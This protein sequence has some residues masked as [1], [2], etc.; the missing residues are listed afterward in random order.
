MTRPTD[1]NL[2]KDSD[3]LVDSLRSTGNKAKA[4]AE[5]DDAKRTGSSIS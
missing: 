3:H 5:L 4:V 2:D 1:E